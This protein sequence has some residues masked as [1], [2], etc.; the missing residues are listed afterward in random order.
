MGCKADQ[1]NKT[2]KGISIKGNH[3][4]GNQRLLNLNQHFASDAD[5]I[6]FAR[7]VGR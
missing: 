2:F 5:Y 4:K 3:Q 6:F 7:S 1:C